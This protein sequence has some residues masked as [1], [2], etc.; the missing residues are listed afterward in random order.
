MIYT[1][2]S[3]AVHRH[4]AA[5]PTSKHWLLLGDKSI[6]IINLYFLIIIYIFA[7]T[8]PDYIPG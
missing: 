6:S 3:S 7:D 4:Q 1:N 2:F 8:L 5:K